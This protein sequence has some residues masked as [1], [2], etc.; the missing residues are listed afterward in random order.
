VQQVG[1]VG[2]RQQVVDL[3]AEVVG[4]LGEAVPAAA[5]GE[6]LKQAGQSAGADIGQRRAC[7]GVGRLPGGSRRGGAPCLR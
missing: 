5:S 7:Q 6:D 1:G 4:E 3:E 2:Q